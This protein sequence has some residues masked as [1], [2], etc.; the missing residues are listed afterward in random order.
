MNIKVQFKIHDP[1]TNQFSVRIRYSQSQE[2]DHTFDCPI[3]KLSDLQ[4]LKS[5]LEDR[6]GRHLSKDDAV[7][8]QQNLI[9]SLIKAEQWT[10][11]KQFG[12]QSNGRTIVTPTGPINA[13][14]DKRYILPEDMTDQ[15]EK[16]GTLE[17]WQSL[18]TYLHQ[19]SILT[20]GVT[21]VFAAPLLKELNRRSCGFI[22][23]G[24]SGGGKSTAIRAAAS[25]AGYMKEKELP[26]FNFTPTGGEENAQAHSGTLWPLDDIQIIAG[27]PKE[28]HAFLEN[29]AYVLV[30]GRGKIKSRHA[31]AN[32]SASDTSWLTY[33]FAGAEETAAGIARSAGAL[34]QG[35]ATARLIDVPFG[36]HIFDRASD[37]DI[38]VAVACTEIAK[39]TEENGGKPLNMF[40][41]RY[42]KDRASNKQKLFKYINEFEN[43]VSG[44]SQ[45]Q[46]DRKVT[47]HF[48]FI[49]AVGALASELNVLPTSR[50]HVLKCIRRCHKWALAEINPERNFVAS[51]LKI[52]RQ[53]RDTLSQVKRSNPSIS[54]DAT[55]FV[56]R[57]GDRL[58]MFIKREH[59][60]QM[61]PHSMQAQLVAKHLAKRKCIH[62]HAPEH[63]GRSLEWCTRQVTWPTNGKPTRPHTIIIDLED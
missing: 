18:S 3:S 10:L 15:Y 58:L 30:H 47:Y 44:R 24:P 9:G 41:K 63:L 59:F 39:I 52:L 20:L 12:L 22:I 43:A 38:D 27:G 53:Y 49:F 23:S 56:R 21:L 6:I 11:V 40:L 1:E 33:C 7:Q 26:S 4:F 57:D 17:G 14:K 55:G 48:A 25:T 28:R 45:S 13:E 32:G 60:L 37:A 50:G 16:R 34:R 29:F 35:G 31:K 62:G 5:G 36:E 54:E 8:I 19:S 61:F 51:G 46:V 42:F 2:K